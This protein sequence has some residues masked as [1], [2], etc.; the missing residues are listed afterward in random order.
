MNFGKLFGKG[1][2][3]KGGGGGGNAGQGKAQQTIQNLDSQIKVLEE[4]INHIEK[5]SKGFEEE[6]KAKLKAGDKVGAKRALVKK[7]KQLEQMKQLE[8][9]LQMLEDQKMMLEGVDTNAD[10]VKALKQGSETLKEVTKGYD[11]NVMEDL[12]NDM[13]DIKDQQAEMN[14]FFKDY[15]DQEQ[16][17]VD[18][19]LAELEE[20]MAKEEVGVLPN[21]NKEVLEKPAAVKNK[22][23]DALNDFLAS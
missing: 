22:E 5:K 3:K 21:A 10:L 1:G 12:K 13:E 19:D 8:G 20:Q 17:G 14:D 7:K 23:E 4:K 15:V 18:D 2:N 9:G 6:A 11:V 16:E